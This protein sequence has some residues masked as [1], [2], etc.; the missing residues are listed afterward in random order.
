MERASMHCMK[1]RVSICHDQIKTKNRTIQETLKELTPLVSS[2]NLMALKDFLKRRAEAVRDNINT[3]HAKKLSNLHNEFNSSSNLVDKSNW[4]VNLSKKPLT[5]SERSLLEKGPK[6]APTPNQI[7][8]KNIVAEVE[9]AIHHLP[10]ESKNFIRNSTATILHKA[11][12][13]S[14]K[15]LNADERKALQDLKKDETRILMK[16]D[17]GNC[18]VVLDKSDYDSKMDSLLSDRTTYELVLKSP[19]KRI[20]RELNKRLLVLKN[21]YKI[22]DSTYRKLHSTDAIP[23]A[24][25]GS[26]KHHKQGNPVRPIVSSI[27]SALYNTSKFLTDILSP[28]QNSNGF[29]VP[30]SAK[31]AEE[32]SNVDIQDDEVMLSF[33][34]VSLF[35]AIPVDK[36]CDYISNKLLKDN[37]LPSRTS[38]DSNEIISL[39]K[40]ILSNN[41]FIYDDKIYKQIHGCA[42]GS[43]VSPV[44]AN[45]CMEA[46][47]EMAI[48]TS[49]VQPKV[50]KR[51]VDDSFCIIKRD[52]VNSFHTTLNSIDPHILFTIEEESDQQIAFLDTLVSRK[53]NTI[54]ID[55]YRK[56][57]HTDRYL[58][59]SSHHDKRHKISTAETL[60]HRA[61]KLPSTPQGKNTEI[62]HVFDALRANN[63]PSFVI[64]NILKQKI[65]QTNHTC[66][67]FT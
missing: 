5:V 40:F 30:N 45:L 66:H 52:A 60:L 63:Y 65:F 15:N 8:H 34:V 46:I 44:V 24:I 51:Y 42:M 38:L 37:S 54:T 32:I 17:K 49:E 23:P 26:I 35:T 19:F 27:G 55:V 50:W 59:F 6:F 12:P 3:R 47:E 4:V 57:T 39:L 36:A 25:R 1:A 16:A 10:E 13:P 29:S 14:H 48:N 21:H 33:D 9:A 62:N 28:L 67:P 11:R 43:P 18:F 61:I 31:F 22:S 20:E 58:D 2:D 41:Y 53:D 64:S 7:P 56:A